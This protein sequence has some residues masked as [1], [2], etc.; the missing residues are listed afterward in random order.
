MPRLTQ[1]FWIL[2]LPHSCSGGGGSYVYSLTFRVGFH[3]SFSRIWAIL[4]VVFTSYSIPFFSVQPFRFVSAHFQICKLC[5]RFANFALVV[6]GN[7][8]TERMDENWYSL[9]VAMRKIFRALQQNNYRF[10]P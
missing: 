2:D 5:F 10:A 1:F 6:R 8:I 9:A 4:L 7:R 3:F